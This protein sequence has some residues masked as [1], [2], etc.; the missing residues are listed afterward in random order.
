M[1]RLN[2]AINDHDIET[3][4]GC[5]DSNYESEQPAHPTRRFTGQEQVRQ[6]WSSLFA[7]MPDLRAQLL[8][9]AEE[10]QTVLAEW[11]WQGTQASGEPFDWRGVTVMGIE[12]QSIVW[13][14]LYMEP[15]EHTGA[16]IVETVRGMTG[17]QNA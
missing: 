17:T 4:V 5:F 12:G 2:R 11:R 13:G 7:S 1:E 8:S 10:N 15:V 3:F 6:N 14:R 9:V 16:D